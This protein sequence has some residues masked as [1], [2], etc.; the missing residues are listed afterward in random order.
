MP[1]ASF[2]TDGDLFV[3]LSDSRGNIQVRRFIRRIIETG[4][5]NNSAEVLTIARGAQAPTAGAWL[6]IGP[7]NEL[8][9]ATGDAGGQN[10]ASNSAQSDSS[11]FGKLLRIRRNPDPFAGATPVYYFYD[12]IAKG[13]RHPSGGFFIGNELYI[14]DRGQTRFGELN[15]TTTTP[16]G[17][18]FGWPFR[19]GNVENQPGA[20]VGLTDPLLQVA[21]GSGPKQGSG[22][23]IGRVF[24]TSITELQS[25]LV[26]ADLDGAMWTVSTSRLTSGA[27]LGASDYERRNEDFQPDVGSIS[28]IVAFASGPGGR[29]YM[30]DR[31]GEIFEIIPG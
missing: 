4:L 8:Y 20:P 27:V 15:R 11:R 6:G 16:T 26:F 21:Y 24:T 25:Q 2:A 3:A 10:D 1:S 17:V 19:E 28:G 7:D 9:L 18:N 5:L 22:L 29:S 31:D 14:G 30:L 23:V 12:M 13:V